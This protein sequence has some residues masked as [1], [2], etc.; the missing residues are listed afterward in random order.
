MKIFAPSYYKDF[1]CIADKCKHNCCIGWEIDIDTDTLEYYRSLNNDL[2][3]EI[4]KNISLEDVPHFKLT[5]N[6]RCPF[7]N[8]KGLCKIISNL[9]E[10]A[11]CQIC[12]DHPRF[13][14]YY[15]T[16]IEFGLGLCCEAATEIILN[17]KENFS[18]VVI[19]EDDSQEFD[20]QA[21]TNL[22][23]IRDSLFEL[24]NTELS[25]CDK[26][27]AII[28]K[29]E[30]VF[31]NI[32]TEYWCDIY[33]NLERLDNSWDTA[34]RKLKN[35]ESFSIEQSDFEL[36]NILNYFIYRHFINISLEFDV[37]LALKFCILSCFIIS[38]ISDSKD[39]LS[40]TA[41]MY[42][43]EIEYSDENIYEIIKAL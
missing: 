40:N 31:K 2:G 39:E 34:L 23:F 38:E 37:S 16:R 11:L 3:N 41:R 14:N 35:K 28:E 15:D 32:K 21:E 24:L 26:V 1:K 43:S 33:E 7:L 10:G 12:T 27:A 20:N 9:G 18:L 5:A 36:S 30:L 13:K 8:E 42:S 29:Y 6:D 22:L 19:G 4:M 17:N 25:F